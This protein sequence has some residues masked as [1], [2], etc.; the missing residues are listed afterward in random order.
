MDK[1]TE[2]GPGGQHHRIREE[3]QTHLGHDTPDLILLDDEVVRRLLK[4]PQIRLVFQSVT[5]SSFVKHAVSLRSG[6]SNGWPLA[7][8]EH[9]KLDAALVGGHRHGPTQ[10]IDFLDQMTL[11]DAT[12]GRV[13]A[14]LAEGF[15][16]VA[17]QQGLHAHACRCQRSL[18]AGMAAAD[19]DH[20]KTGREVHHAPRACSDGNSGSREV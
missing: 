2:E 9:A 12:D 4:Y 5:N 3:T 19:N 14:H 20:V 6:G 16:I 11:A 18:G 8:V 10:R 7:A 13:A 15:H 17:E 1:S